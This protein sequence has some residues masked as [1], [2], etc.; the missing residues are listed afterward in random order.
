MDNL[1]IEPTKSTPLI[2]FKEGYFI[3]EGQSYPENPRQFFLPIF[4][5]IKDYFKVK[6]DYETRVDLHLIYFNT[7]SS[8]CIMDILDIF[9]EAHEAGH[10]IVFNWYYETDNEDIL[11]TG[12]ELKEDVT[13]E[14]N[15]IP[16][17]NSVSLC[18]EDD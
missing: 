2:N 13:F 16:L 15:I 11:E 10:K 3:I 18:K 4:S 12:N 14:F 5:W 9:Q 17:N 7:S 6:R 8:K 1:R